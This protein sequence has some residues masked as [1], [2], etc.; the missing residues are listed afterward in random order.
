MIISSSSRAMVDVRYPNQGLSDISKAGMNSIMLDMSMYFDLDA[1]GTKEYTQAYQLYWERIDHFVEIC[2][3]QKIE[4]SSIYA[5]RIIYNTVKVNMLEEQLKLAKISIDLARRVHCK[6]VVIDPIVF[7]FDLLDLYK[8]NEKF[9]LE[10][11]EYIGEDCIRILLKNMCRNHNGHNIRGIC[12]NPEQVVEWLDCFNSSVGKNQFGFCLDV[13]ICNLVGQDIYSMV[14]GLASNLDVVMIRES[15]GTNDANLLPFSYSLFG[16]TP[17]DWLGM[18]RGLRTINF[19]GE[20]VFMISDTVSTFSILLRPSLYLLVKSMGDYFKW[21]IEM[22]QILSKYSKIV[23]FGA[24]N[25]CRN[26]LKCY[27]NKYPPLFTCDNNSKLWGTSFCGLEV[28]NPEELLKLS[29]DT[30]VFICN[31]FYREIKEQLISMGV[32]NIEFFSDEYLPTYY[33]DRI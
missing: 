25:M 21:Q 1:F 11:A 19:M 7:G 2:N 15:D 9:Y 8:I 6:K 10:L 31:L 26:Y 3:E 33:F 17:T 12:S 24:G 28:K 16:Q 14:S 5:P 27:S 32:N 4:I 23:L 13:G 30:G 29:D 20:L 22:E 18:I